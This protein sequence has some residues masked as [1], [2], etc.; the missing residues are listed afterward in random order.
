M[1]RHVIKEKIKAFD[2]LEPE[3]R[4]Q[5]SQIS[6]RLTAELILAVA[7][8]FLIGVAMVFSLVPVLVQQRL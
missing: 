6:R 3:E 5:L 8:R 4:T 1:T 7:V 2:E